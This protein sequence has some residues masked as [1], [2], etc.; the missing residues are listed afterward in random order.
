MREVGAVPIPHLIGETVTATTEPVSTAEMVP[1]PGRA[2]AVLAGLGLPAWVGC[3]VL[4]Y[5]SLGPKPEG[6]QTL[7]EQARMYQSGGVAI[8]AFG[9]L[10]LVAVVVMAAAV[11]AIARPLAASNRARVLSRLA[12]AA[13]VIAAVAEVV[14]EIALF[15]LLAADA[16]DLPGWVSGLMEGQSANVD[17]NGISWTLFAVAATLLAFALRSAR[18]LPRAGLVIGIIGA[19]LTVVAAAAAF[20][21]P[22]TAAVLLFALGA[23]LARRRR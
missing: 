10:A 15:G 21:V 12:I 2:A 16:D 19:A 1:T 6:E 7:A 20:F 5:G 3:F 14:N 11:V 22:M 17:I 9:A 18:V 13:A 23:S 8:W 4:L